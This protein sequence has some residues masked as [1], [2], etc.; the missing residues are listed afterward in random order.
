MVEVVGV[1]FVVFFVGLFVHAMRFLGAYCQQKK[2]ETR[3]QA[4]E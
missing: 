4:N 1:V 2:P 3:G